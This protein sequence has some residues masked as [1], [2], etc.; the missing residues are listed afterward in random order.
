M[1]EREYR[2]ALGAYATGVAVVTAGTEAEGFAGITINS[3]ASVSLKPRLILWSLGDQS[4]RY[5][6]FAATERFGVS[7]LGADQK[8]TA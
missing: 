5:D 1:S 6:Q 2:A 8:E 7:F 3:F 4:E